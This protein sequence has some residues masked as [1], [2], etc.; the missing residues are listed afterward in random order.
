MMLHNSLDM[1]TVAT[2]GWQ[3][4]PL[5]KSVDMMISGSVTKVDQ[6]INIETTLIAADGN[7]VLSQINTARKKK[8]VGNT[9]KLIAN[10][11]ID[12][13]PFEGTIAAIDAQGYRINLGKSDYRIRRGSRF[14]Y[15]VASRGS[16]MPVPSVSSRPMILP[17]GLRLSI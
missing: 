9:A 17:H 13:F 7:I 12:Q 16:R 8:N 5:I 4:A 2:K 1:E 6:G 3:H 11:I 10:S 14:R 15:P